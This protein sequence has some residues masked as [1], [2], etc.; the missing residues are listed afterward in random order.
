MI[1]NTIVNALRVAAERYTEDATGTRKTSERVAAQFDSQA[2]EATRL[3]DANRGGR[4]ARSRL[5]RMP[6][7]VTSQQ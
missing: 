4:T 1:E 5:S 7:G 3:A 2:K 6:A